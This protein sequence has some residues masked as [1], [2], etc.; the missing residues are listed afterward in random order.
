LGVPIFTALLATLA[1]DFF[2]AAAFFGAVF[3]EVSFAEAFFAG[4]FFF[5]IVFLALFFAIIHLFSMKKVGEY[6]AE[7]SFRQGVN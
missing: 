4:A 5:V 7:S 3:L 2:F 6:D 1:V